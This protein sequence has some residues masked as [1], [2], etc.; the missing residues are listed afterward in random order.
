MD[1]TQIIYS[2]PYSTEKNIGKALNEFCELVPENAWICLQDGDIMYLTPD[3]GRQI[4]EVIERH[5]NDFDLFGCVTNRLGRTIQRAPEVDYN[6]HD[7]KYHYEIAVKLRDANYCEVKDITSTR[8]IAG[9]FMLFRKSLWNRIKF[10]ENTP[11]F[12][13][14]FSHSVIQQGGRLGLM[15]GLYIYH[16]YRIWS[17]TPSKDRT[18]L[19]P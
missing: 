11:F 8:Y 16:L 2:N 5:G 15:T 17:D 13:D 6:N 3:W 4:A 19:L 10:Q 18:H 7:I 12:D 9:M 14:H 1:K